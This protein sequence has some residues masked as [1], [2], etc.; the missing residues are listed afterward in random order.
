MIDLPARN[1]TKAKNI[2]QPLMLLNIPEIEIPI[3]QVGVLEWKLAARTTKKE[4]GAEVDLNA[5]VDQNRSILLNYANIVL[6]GD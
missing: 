1:I 5:V 6:H 2:P 4:N 3:D